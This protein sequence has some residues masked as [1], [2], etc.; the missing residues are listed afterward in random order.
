[1]RLNLFFS[2]IIKAHDCGVYM[3]INIPLLSFGFEASDHNKRDVDLHRTILVVH[4]SHHL[5]LATPI[6]L[7]DE[8]DGN[9]SDCVIVEPSVSSEKAI[10]PEDEESSVKFFRLEPNH[11]NDS[12]IV[13]DETEEL[14]SEDPLAAISDQSVPSRKMLINNEDRFN[15]TW[16]LIIYCYKIV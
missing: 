8:K 15:I 7:H 1:M 3:L 16:Q 11:S 6:V 2:V 10:T 12:I 9:D 14:D 13:S 4:L 5:F